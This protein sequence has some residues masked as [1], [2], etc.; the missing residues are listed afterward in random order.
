M[1]QLTAFLLVPVLSR[2][3]TEADYGITGSMQALTAVLI[4]AMTLSMD[5]AV[6]RIYW[7]CDSED[8]R[9]RYFGTVTLALWGSATA[10]LLVLLAGHSVLGRLYRSIPFFPYYAYAI[11]SAY[12][13]RFAM[14]P[15][16]YMQIRERP[17]LFVILSL[18]QLVFQTGLPL[19]F[20]VGR[21]EGAMGMLKG[22]MIA[23][24]ITAPVFVAINIRIMRFTFLWSDL[25]RTLRFSL[26]MLPTLMCAWVLNM[27]DRILLER[28]LS[29]EDV[30]IFVIA[31]RISSIVLVLTNGFTRAYMPVFYKT[32]NSADQSKAR[33]VL[34]RYGNAY[35]LT[36]LLLCFGISLFSREAIHFLLPA[37]FHRASQI[38]PLLSL[39]FFVSNWGS[40]MNLCLYQ[41]HRTELVLL[42][43]V[44]GVVT[45]I[46]CS[47]TMIP[48]IGVIGSACSSVI[49]FSVVFLVKHEITRRRFFVPFGWHPH[50]LFLLLGA[51]LVCG[52][53]MPAMAEPVR[54]IAKLLGAALMVGLFA[55]SGTGSDLLL[56]SFRPSPVA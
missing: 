6:Y 8:E 12:L 16:A 1:P 50:L 48:W 19:W 3:L 22:Q 4:I 44:A 26:P 38:V 30:G 46:A 41:L 55:R 2:H 17:G 40:I 34:R 51:A 53:N 10:M 36:T 29:L 31:F 11:A 14:I 21:G 49:A 37:R 18:L 24:A 9:R 35:V 56:S 15:K 42:A 28:L 32:V 13:S 20:V 33:A 5:R 43:S 25:S 7:D 52:T 45:K 27:F 54:I 39:A 47:L 23:S